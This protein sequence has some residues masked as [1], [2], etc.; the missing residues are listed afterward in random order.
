MKR[1]FPLRNNILQ[2]F[3]FA[4]FIF[5]PRFENVTTFFSFFFP[6]ESILDDVVREF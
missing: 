5:S 1:G 4:H 6:F 2:T 3:I